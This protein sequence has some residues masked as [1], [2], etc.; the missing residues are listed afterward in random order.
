MLKLLGPLES[1]EQSDALDPCTAAPFSF[2]FVMRKHLSYKLS[3][4]EAVRRRRNH[5]KGKNPAAQLIRSGPWF[6]TA[7]HHGKTLACTFTPTLSPARTRSEGVRLVRRMAR[8]Q[9]RSG[10]LLLQWLAVQLTQLV[11]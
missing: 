9:L 8:T 7:L 11:S 5:R 6:G 2:L 1:I 4:P 10:H 3:F